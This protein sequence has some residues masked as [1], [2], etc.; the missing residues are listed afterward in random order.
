[1][2]SQRRCIPILYLNFSNI[3]VGNALVNKT[4]RLSLERICWTSISPFCWRS[5]VEKNFGEMRFV[6]LLWCILLLIEWYMQHYLH[7]PWLVYF[8]QRKITHFLNMVGHWSQPNALSTCF[9]DGYYFCMI[10]RSGYQRLL[11]WLRRY[12]RFSTRK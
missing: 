10:W 6:N 2:I 9:M 4:A 8:F 7:T 5:C 12:C 3:D 1:L 11:H